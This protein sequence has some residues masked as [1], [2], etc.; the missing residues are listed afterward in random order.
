MAVNP[1]YVDFVARG[2][3][4]VQKAIRSISQTITDAEN[5][6]TAATRAQASEREKILAKEAGEKVRQ[7]QRSSAMSAAATRAG[8]TETARAAR[9]EARA[10][11]QGANS[12][13]RELQR[14]QAAERRARSESLRGAVAKTGVTGIPHGPELSARSKVAAMKAG[15]RSA[16]RSIKS[17]HRE[18]DRAAKAEVAAAKAAAKEKIAAM[19]A[20]D[21]VIE[22]AR[23]HGVRVA[24]RA[25]RDEVKVFERGER[26]KN[27]A[28][29]RWVRRRES[30]QRRADAESTRRREKFANTVTG[31]GGRA[32]SS[33]M[34]VVQRAGTGLFTGVTG[35]GGGYGLADSVQRSVGIRGHLAD[36]AN[37]GLIASDPANSKRVAVDDLQKDVR[38][39]GT[40]YGIDPEKGAAALDKFASKTGKLNV[41]R[42]LLSGLAEMSRAGAGDLDDLADAAGDVFSGDTTQNAEQVLAVMR[43]LA[44]Q[45][46]IGAVEMKDLAS[47]MTKISA[48]AGQFQGDA[49]KNMATMGGLAQ[50]A[51]TAAGGAASAPQAANAVQALTAQFYK[52]ARIEGFAKLGVKTKDDKT[53]FNRNLEDVLIESLQ[54]AE[55]VSRKKGH[56]MR[57]FDVVL[58]GAIADVGARR[59]VN[60]LAKAYKE[61]GGG[62]AGTKAA[63]DLLKQF[64]GASMSKEE[65]TEAASKRMQ[66]ADAQLEIAMQKLRN[67]TSES[68]TPALTQLTSKLTELVPLVGRMLDGFVK[69]AD[70]ASKN[71]FEGFG[72]LVTGFFMKEL[73]AAQIGA[74]IKS[75]ISGAAGGG[76]PGVGTAASSAPGVAGSGAAAAGAIGLGVAMQ[77]GSMGNLADERY[78]AVKAGQTQAQQLAAD[79]ASGDP[80][81]AAAARRQIEAAKGKSGFVDKAGAYLDTGLRAAEA[82]LN[83]LSYVTTKAT[84]YGLEKAG[85]QSQAQRSVETIKANEVANAPIDRLVAAIEANTKATETN[86]RT[87][88]VSASPSAPGVPSGP[89]PIKDSGR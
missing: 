73:I 34:G 13:I 33:A 70:W 49:G 1:V 17:G 82:V 57:D 85:V 28:A 71:P 12:K 69:L 26:E 5:R 45:G 87:T 58:G 84:D 46:K 35:I 9:D 24:E 78:S 36:I 88:G 15:D 68:L 48:A 47:Q 40:R 29:S 20:A 22:Q 2:M 30:E 89:G 55:K 61:A 42:Q 32:A 16:E 18:A 64:A 37:R 7:S 54:G 52:N 41:G 11:T 81:K 63:Q 4:Q 75:V 65:V 51:R 59:A 31:A 62:A 76:V 43:A 3:P 10:A 67:T 53:G 86:S 21:R 60:P 50:M 14:V 39:V 27:Q 23:A 66:E 25:A 38:T 72:A 79:I 77:V 8:A 44:A 74:T 6:A 83:P 56:G 19:K 80:A